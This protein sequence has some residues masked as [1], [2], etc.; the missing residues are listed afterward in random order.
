LFKIIQVILEKKRV[1][2]RAADTD[3]GQ[4]FIIVIEQCDQFRH[5]ARNARAMSL[6]VSLRDKLFNLPPARM[7]AVDQLPP[8][9]SEQFGP[10][11]ETRYRNQ[12]SVFQIHF[13][14]LTN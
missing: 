9:R 8:G 6:K 14:C 1:A 13:S 11:G 5:E 4:N 12:G 10:V 7:L 2:G 3:R